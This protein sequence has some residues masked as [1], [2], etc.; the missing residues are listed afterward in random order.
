MPKLT[1]E[2]SKLVL[3]ALLL[4]VFGTS[5]TF[6][7][8]RGYVTNFDHNTVSVI[9]TAT[10]AVIATVTVGFEPTGIAVTPDGAFVY[11]VNGSAHTVSVISAA[12]NTVV[13]TVPVGT[14][15]IGIAITPNGAFAYVTNQFASNVSIIDTATNTV[16]D[17]IPLT[18]PPGMLAFTPNGA[19]AYVTGSAFLGGA[20]AIMVIPQLTLWS[21][22]CR[23]PLARL[24]EE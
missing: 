8:T 7:Q 19:F 17:T 12:T 11:V 14:F 10:H 13:A 6:A 16:V 20:S 24:Y 5:V 23:C 15:P 18:V 9:D 3:S 21:P 2:I 22:P 1:H 4:T